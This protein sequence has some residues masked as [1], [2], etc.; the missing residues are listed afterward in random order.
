LPGSWVQYEFGYVCATP[1]A[2]DLDDDGRLEVIFGREV[3]RAD[4][5]ELW[6]TDTQPGYPHVADL[7]GD[8]RPEVVIVGGA[9]AGLAGYDAKGQAL[10]EPWPAEPCNGGWGPGSIQDVDGDGALD[11]FGASCLQAGAYRLGSSGPEPLWSQPI[12]MQ[13]IAGD[14]ASTSFDFLGRGLPHALYADDW[15]YAFDGQTG[16]VALKTQARFGTVIE[17]PVVADVDNDRSADIVVS[18]TG[19][20]KNAITVYQDAEQRWIPARR[21]WNQHAYHVTNVRED[22][23]IPAQMAKHWTKL[24]TFRNNAQVDDAGACDPPE[25]K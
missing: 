22:G 21:I 13:D 14:P 4:G 23:T 9:F 11:F 15:L 16:A 3:Y 5:T 2:A 25:P 6:S 10:W 19:E 18:S 7:D 12:P 1:T 24:N 20:G 8:G 17:F